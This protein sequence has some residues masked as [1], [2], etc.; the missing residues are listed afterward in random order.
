MIDKFEANLKHTPS[1]IKHS[2]KATSSSDVT[3]SAFSSTTVLHFSVLCCDRELKKY[4]KRK[5]AYIPEWEMGKTFVL[6]SFFFRYF[7]LSQD[8]FK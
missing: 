7:S 3:S 6:N 2:F 1:T 4:N 8:R 5:A